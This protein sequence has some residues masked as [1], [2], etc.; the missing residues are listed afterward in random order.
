MKEWKLDYREYP[1]SV[2]MVIGPKVKSGRLIQ[3]R[4]IRWAGPVV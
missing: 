3:L 1:F 4:I 2:A